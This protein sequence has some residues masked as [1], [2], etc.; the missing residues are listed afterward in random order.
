MPRLLRL[1]VLLHAAVVASSGLPS[2]CLCHLM[3]PS[4]LVLFS[5]FSMCEALIFHV[6]SYIMLDYYNTCVR[7]RAWLGVFYR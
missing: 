2:A 1:V 3:V 5:L 4:C 6:H 7:T